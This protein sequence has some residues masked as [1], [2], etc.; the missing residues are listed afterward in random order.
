[1]VRTVLFPSDLSPRSARA[2]DHARFLAERFGARLTLYHVNE[3]PVEHL[4]YWSPESEAAVRAERLAAERLED[5]AA[6]L[7]VP[8]GVV[9]YTRTSAAGALVKYMRVTRPDLTVMATHGRDGLSH[10]VLGSVA[11]TVLRRAGRPMLC[12]REPDHGI[13][14]PYR[15]ILVPTDLSQMSR[16]AFPMAALLARAFEAEIIAVHVASYPTSASLSGI[17]RSVEAAVDEERVWTFLQPECAGLRV[18]ARVLAGS[19]ADRI[20]E[21]A[22]AESADIIV[23]PTRDHHAL[24]ARVLGSHTERVVRRASCPV[25]AV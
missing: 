6:R 20:V 18:T 3:A 1:M 8:H 10:L 22:A 21:S 9:V 4:R 25:L 13:A 24:A 16:R 17:P 15:R 7:T 2:F 11:E 5:Q 12:V 14:L 23:M 19:A